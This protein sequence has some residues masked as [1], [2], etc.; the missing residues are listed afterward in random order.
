[1]RDNYSAINTTRQ[2]EIAN[3]AAQQISDIARLASSYQAEGLTRTQALAMAEN[4][5][6]KGYRADV[7]LSPEQG[8]RL[9]FKQAEDAEVQSNAPR[10]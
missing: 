2:N 3:S 6:P 5:H 7:V 10:G 4:A 1:M 8:A 9:G